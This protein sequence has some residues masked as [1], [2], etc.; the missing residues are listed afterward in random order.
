MQFLGHVTSKDDIAK[1]KTNLAM[2]LAQAHDMERARSLALDAHSIVL[3]ELSSQQRFPFFLPRLTA[4][5]KA[6]QLPDAV[7][8]L[9]ETALNEWYGMQTEG[10]MGASAR[11]LLES[12]FAAGKA[13]AGLRAVKTI[14]PA[15]ILHAA[16][17]GLLRPEDLG[18]PRPEKLFYGLIEMMGWT[19][20][21]WGA[22]HNAL[23]TDEGDRAA[24]DSSKEE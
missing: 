23:V 17:C 21:F 3:D 22:Y 9:L 11:L 10:R 6:S 4:V 15:D 24:I 13:L 14:D 2:R 12:Y 16:G 19:S 5:L 1:I 18:K 20:P 8:E 7:N